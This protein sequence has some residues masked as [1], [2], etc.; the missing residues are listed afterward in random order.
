MTA[1]PNLVKFVFRNMH[2]DVVNEKLMRVLRRKVDEAG[3]AAS[4]ARTHQINR[5]YI[6]NILAGRA[7]PGPKVLDAIGF[8]RVVTYRPKPPP[9]KALPE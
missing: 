7:T 9:Q 2:G 3:G 8:E 5:P 1:I 6:T 4:F